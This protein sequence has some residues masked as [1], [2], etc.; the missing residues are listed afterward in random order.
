[1]HDPYYG[2]GQVHTANGSSMN[3][4]HIGNSVIPT[5]PPHCDLIINNVLHVSSSHK[6]LI[7]VHHFTLDNDT[8]IEFHLF[9]FLIMDQKVRK[10]LLHGMCKG[11]L[12]PLPPSTS[13]F[14]KLVFSAIKISIDRWHNCL[15]HPSCDIVSRVIAKNNLP[16]ASSDRSS[17]SL[18]GACT[19]AKAHQ[20]RYSISSSHSSA[21]LELVFSDVWG[22]AIDSF[23][24]KKYYVSFI[25]D[26]S[27][28]TWIYLLCHKSE[29]SKYFLEF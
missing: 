27:K 18:C 17:A 20:L 19:C 23:G 29:V 26:Y 15:C 7:S 25:D 28:F 10:V 8:F 2:N 21:P 1:M 9:F 22:A 13:K 24:R 3:I 16:C 5:P 6:N 11:G 4:T 14:W 12:Y